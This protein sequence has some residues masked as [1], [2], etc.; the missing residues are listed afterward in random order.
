MAIRPYWSGTIRVS[1]VS[2]SVDMFTAL[3]AGQKIAFHQIY[4][5]TGERVRQKLVA[6]D[7]EVERADIV[8]GYEVEKGEYVLFEPDEIKDLKIASSKAMEMV[9]FVPYDAV[10]AIYFD[11]PYYLAPSGKGDLAT[12]CVIRDSMREMKVMGIGQIVI[13]GSER[14]CA[15]KPCGPGLL[16]ETLHYADEI[17]KSGY[18]F[19]DIKDVSTDADEKD[20]AKQLIKRKVGEFEPEE[21]HDRYSDALR[22]LV[23]SRLENREPVIPEERPAAKVVNLMDALRASLREPSASAAN[24]SAEKPKVKAPPKAKAKPAAQR[25][26]G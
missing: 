25:K 6:G 24:D 18:V 11:T 3:D 1:L 14:L 13:S 2:L 12:F 9:R 21:F 26:A 17:K 5:P 22:E 4:K 10:D 20:L 8:K 7:V 19:G 23:D 16:L 15:I